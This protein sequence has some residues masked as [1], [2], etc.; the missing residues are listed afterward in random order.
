MPEELKTQAA[1]KRK[2]AQ[3]IKGSKEKKAV[4]LPAPGKGREKETDARAPP[5]RYRGAMAFSI[6]RLATARLA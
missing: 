5:T 4:G 6:A 1:A 2:T 3:A